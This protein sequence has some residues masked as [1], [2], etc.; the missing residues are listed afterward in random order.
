MIFGGSWLSLAC[1]WMMLASDRGC[2]GG[3]GTG[4]RANAA[5]EPS[6]EDRL[7]SEVGGI[8]WSIWWNREGGADVISLLAEQAIFILS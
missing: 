4:T 5:D 8:A 7:F 6:K 2:G 1:S 3:G